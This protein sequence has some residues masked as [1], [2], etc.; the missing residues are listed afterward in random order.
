MYINF[1]DSQWS[2]VRKNYDRWWNNSLDRPIINAKVYCLQNDYRPFIDEWIS[3]KHFSD[4]SITP[5][6]IAERCVYETTNFEYIADGY[7]H[8][9]NVISGPG[10]LSAYLGCE[11]INNQGWTWFHP[12]KDRPSI[13]KL[14]LKVDKN[15]I[16]FK[17]TMEIFKYEIEYSQ[18]NIVISFPDMG[19]I[20]DV[21]ASFFPS[22]QLPLALYD[23]PDD[24]K[25]LLNEIKDAWIACYEEFVNL[26]KGATKGYTS[27]SPV[28]SE[29]P[30]YIHQ[31]DFSYMLSTD[32]FEEFV[33]PHLN[34]IFTFVENSM[35]HLDGIGALPHLALLKKCNNL[36]CIQWVFGDGKGSATKWADV[37]NEIKKAGKTNNQMLK[38]EEMFNMKKKMNG[39][40]SFYIDYFVDPSETV[41][42]VRDR[43]NNIIN[44]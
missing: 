20:M 4:L 7:P 12:M 40:E 30:C 22:D 9:N 18:G 42:Q 23:N 26:F 29:V 3:Q 28:Y 19:G 1:D 8:I 41:E 14:S 24:V 15:N 32:M 10:I 21:L 33:L 27:W 31:S 38:Y 44:K 34:E 16:W 39:L 6:Q 35:Y 5:K 17:R 2:K 11:V 13:N 37:F 25:R 43:T 36:K